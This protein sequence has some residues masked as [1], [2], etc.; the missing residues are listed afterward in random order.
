M[1]TDSRELQGKCGREEYARKYCA[2]H[3]EKNT[4][5]N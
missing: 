2:F 1:A 3:I 5:S 4:Q